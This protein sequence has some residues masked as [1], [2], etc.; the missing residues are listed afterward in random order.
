MINIIEKFKNYQWLRSW[1]PY[2][3]IFALGFLLY[4]QILS[5]DL[6]YL[7]DNT[8]IIDR[9]EVLKDIKNVPLIFSTDAFFSGTNFYY[10]PLLNLSFMFDAQLAGG[11]ELFFYFLDNILLHIIAVC[12]LFY[13]LKKII[14]KDAL[15]FFLS[16]VFLVHPAL[17]QAVAWLP[18]RN[19]SLV[20]I[21]VLVTFLALINFSIKPQLKSLLIYGVLFFLAIL[22]KETA[23]FLP[24]LAIVY[25]FS[26]GK[27]DKL[28]WTDRFLVLLFSFASGFIWLLLRSFAFGK[29]NIGTS[30]A[31]QSL[32]SNLPNALIM[33]AKMILPFNLSV[34]PIAADSSFILSIIAIPVFIILL[35]VSRRK[36]MN[37]L[38]FGLAWFLIFFL[39]PF[40]ISSAAPFILEHRLYLPMIGFLIML[41]EIQWLKNLDFSKQKVKI[42]CL[43]FLLFF[44]GLTFT[45]SLSFR[46]KLIFWQAAVKTSPHSPLAQ[47]NLGAM[48]Y[49]D[50]DLDAAYHYYSKSLELSP[51]EP[52]I[53]NN[54]GLI[55]ESKGDQKNAELEYTKELNLYPNYDKALLNLG[56]LYYK[57]NKISEARYLFEAALRENP[58]NY[59]AY[60]S[61]LNLEKT[62]R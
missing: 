59:E 45:H 20:T 26:A 57:Q 46:N 30:E 58:Y 42:Y 40:F 14:K 19:D 29:E 34:L 60:Q 1:R 25:F 28:S 22:T 56:N 11:T 38:F 4:S 53:H 52:M 24:F 16:L 49:L 36:N 23:I 44:A 48:Y 61:L 21:F 43:V 32:M 47:K 31:L 41:S 35:I 3:V 55:Y 2:F 8:L 18:G 15:A 17:T 62:L 7:D 9:Y 54:L 6:T 12:L 5:F 51:K 27:S 33:A 10:R 39:P 13:F 50:G 37:N